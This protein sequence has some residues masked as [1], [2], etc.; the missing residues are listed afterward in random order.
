MRCK[1]IFILTS[2]F[3]LGALQMQLV[4]AD[5]VIVPHQPLP[6][7]I[8]LGEFYSVKYHRVY[9]EILEQMVTTTVEQA[10]LNETDRAIEVQYIFP[11][12]RNSQVNKF[13]LIVEDK[14]I[15]GRILEKG[16]A[17]R[18][19]EEIVRRQRD[20]A[21]LEYIDHDMFRTSVFPL[22]SQG[23]RTVKLVYS[24]LLS[25]DGNRI[26]Y[27]YP[28][29]TEK[30]SK[31]VLEE[32]RIDFELTSSA[33]VK[34]VYSPTQDFK[35]EWDGNN[36][37]KGHWSDE[38][39]RP[40][41][42]FRLF[43]ILSRDRVGATLFS[44]RP[45]KSEGGY[46]LLLASPQMNLKKHKTINKN[47]I[48][49]LDVSGSM[50]GTKIE[51]ARG[52]ARFITENL[53]SDDG[54][55]IIFY[56]SMVD[57]LWD[58]LRECS[59]TAKREALSRIDRSEAGGG[60][61]IHAALTT[62]LHQ[63]LGDNRPNY[64]IFLTDGLP[65]SGITQ[66]DKII[67]DV[68]KENQYQSRLFAFGV[69]YDVNAILLDRLGADNS[70]MAEY[71]P[72]GEDIEAKVSSFYSKIQNPA[73]TGPELDFGNVRIRD[74]YPPSL[75]DIFY[76]GQLVL[77]GRYR[78]TGRTTVTL[79][80]KAMDEKPTFAYT[81]DFVRHT[82]REE[83][84]FV[85]RLWA[86]KKIG[87]LIEQVR[88]Y[89][90]K[91][92]HVDEIVALSTRYGIM[93]QY[94]SFLADDDVE[95]DDIAAVR[96]RAWDAMEDAVG[97]QTGAPGVSQ[98][99]HSGQLK[100]LVQAPTEAKFF[101][102]SGK[103]I[104]LEKVKLIGSKTFYFKKGK[105]VDAEYDEQMKLTEIEYFSDD[106]FNLAKKAPSQA[107]YLTFAPENIIVTVIEGIAYK[108]IPAK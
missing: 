87:W 98:S 30:F 14:E 39:V 91:K 13:S 15:P 84:A 9:V 46:F 42:D 7:P 85:A 2:L 103:Q 80:G 3:C 83:F 51:Q 5:G 105:W 71:V 92:E 22:P 59:P 35:L 102:A 86:Q 48:L 33:D 99:M 41:N 66:L 72:P 29:N 94:T 75:P 76:G 54:F 44:Y 70:G 24:E 61:D 12:P 82:D 79:T 81:L 26:E 101:D 23:E 104:R 97:V 38:G 10:F 89:G 73:L 27:R 40:A 8:R 36:C 4:Q 20:P 16:E 32:V 17:R 108:I 107:K 50:K 65:T 67:G 25:P 78:D 63:I 21:L 19:Y 6:Q 53:D 74:T 31:K 88:L 49:V 52:A 95:I 96:E 37:V 68:Q 90:E 55:N 106:F 64:L 57:P 100:R 62:A 1:W 34:T 56:N 45:D 43:W 60:T 77:T 18:I 47:I 58:K 93:T 69:G 11:L 28:L